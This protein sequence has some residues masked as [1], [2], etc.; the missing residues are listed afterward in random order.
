MGPH[1]SE[2]LVS[3]DSY[4]YHRGSFFILENSALNITDG[5]F[6]PAFIHHQNVR[7]HG[8]I[9]YLPRF[10]VLFFYHITKLARNQVTY[11]ISYKVLNFKQ[12]FGLA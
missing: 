1:V 11:F 10:L 5:R 4:T 3:Q 9:L 8:T 2:R 6:E 12:L 7:G